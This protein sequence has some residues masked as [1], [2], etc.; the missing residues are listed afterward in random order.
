M[1]EPLYIGMKGSVVAVDR[2]SGQTIWTTRLGGSRFVVV[3]LDGDLVIAHTK[4][5]LFA[6]DAD[7]GRIQWKNGLPGMGYGYA[8]IASAN[9]GANQ[10]VAAIKQ[11]MDQQAAA[12]SSGAA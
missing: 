6:L 12:A 4:G 5:E 3:V 2:A 10:A 8:T 1:E 7:T 9:I 11:L